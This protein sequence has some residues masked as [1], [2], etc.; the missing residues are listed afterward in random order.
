MPMRGI[1][2]PIYIHKPLEE[3]YETVIVYLYMVHNTHYIV[4]RIYN[5]SIRRNNNQ[6]TLDSIHTVWEHSR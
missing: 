5:K 2:I 1:R 6:K 3:V 4:E